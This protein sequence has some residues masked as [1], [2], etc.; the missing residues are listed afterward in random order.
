MNATFSKTVF[1]KGRD[2]EK[3]FYMSLDI[4]Q[5][6]YL[7]AATENVVVAIIVFIARLN[8]YLQ[9]WQPGALQ[10]AICT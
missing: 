2:F 10:T 6:S 7:R 5:Y 8:Q 3:S 1:L 4:E 9:S